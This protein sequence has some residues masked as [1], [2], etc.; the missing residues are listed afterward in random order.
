MSLK[1]KQQRSDVTQ[2]LVAPPDFFPASSAIVSETQYRS[3]SH[4]NSPRTN[5][6]KA[7]M[8]K[9]R[10]L[11]KDVKFTPELCQKN[12]GLIRVSSSR[13]LKSNGVSPPSSNQPKT[14]DKDPFIMTTLPTSSVKCGSTSANFTTSQKQKAPL[15]KPKQKVKKTSLHSR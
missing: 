10:L 5:R 3:K 15:G 9:G 11:I 12:E 8:H 6:N 1:S 13:N 4:E 2:A 7:L 14:K